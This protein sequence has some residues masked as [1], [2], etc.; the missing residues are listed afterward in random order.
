MR[1]PKSALWFLACLVLLPASADATLVRRSVDLSCWNLPIGRDY[2]RQNSP[3]AQV[4]GAPSRRGAVLE[5]MP[6]L[7]ECCNLTLPKV[8]RFADAVQQLQCESTLLG[9]AFQLTKVPWQENGKELWSVVSSRVGSWFSFLRSCFYELL[10]WPFWPWNVDDPLL[11]WMWM[12][13]FTFF[14]CGGI[15]ACWN[16]FLSL[17]W[18]DWLI[19]F[20]L[21]TWYFLTRTI[22]ICDDPLI[23][24]GWLFCFGL[25]GWIL[26]GSTISILPKSNFDHYKGR[27]SKIKKKTNSIP[28]S[29]RVQWN[30]YLVL[31]CAR[32]GRVRHSVRFGRYRFR[33]RN[34]V[35][36][37]Y[38]KSKNMSFHR[39]VEKKPGI[40]TPWFYPGPWPSDES[41]PQNLASCS[42]QNCRP[43][44]VVNRLHQIVKHDLSGGMG[45]GAAATKR[46]RQQ[47]KNSLASA[48]ENFLESW[49]SKQISQEAEQ[50]DSQ[51]RNNKGKG[52]NPNR[53]SSPRQVRLKPDDP[54]SG[55]PNADG[56]LAR[57]L[58]QTLKLCLNQGV[59][60]TEVANQVLAQIRSPGPSPKN[61]RPPDHA[62]KVGK[63]KGNN[64]RPVDSSFDS[65]NITGLRPSEWTLVPQIISFQKFQNGLNEGS[66]HPHNIVEIRSGNDYQQFVTLRNAFEDSSPITVLFSGRDNPPIGST[67]TRKTVFRGKLGSKTEVV[68]LKA[69]GDSTKC[70]WNSRTT[71]VAKKD[72][73][74]V[75][76]DTVRVVAPF[77]YRQLFLP[78]NQHDSPVLVLAAAAWAAEVPVSTLTGGRWT[79][80]TYG[81]KAVL[82][83]HIRLSSKSAQK[84]CEVSGN[85]GI[86]YTI[87]KTD[88]HTSR[89]PVHWFQKNVGESPENFFRRCS[90]LA[91]DRK[92]PLLLRQGGGSDLGCL[93]IA[94]DKTESRTRVYDLWGVPRDWDEEE[95]CGLLS[96][97]KW[98]D[99]QV[100]SKKRIKGQWSWRIRGKSAGDDPN[101]GSWN[102]SIEDSVPWSLEILLAPPKSPNLSTEV[103][104]APRKRFGDITLQDFTH[105]CQQTRGRSSRGKGSV[106]IPERER[107]RS[108]RKDGENKPT[109]E[110]KQNEQ[111]AED[112]SD[113]QMDPPTQP[114]LDEPSNPDEAVRFFEWSLVDWGGTG[115]CGFR[116]IFDGWCKPENRSSL[117]SEQVRRKAAWL[118][119]ETVSHLRKHQSK[120]AEVITEP[121]DKFLEKPLPLHFG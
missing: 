38:G 99:I 104:P 3:G 97:L 103:I 2:T 44:P 84:L 35:V 109:E 87:L 49:T 22:P 19:C 50:G 41:Q 6:C 114:P 118:R 100:L 45:A 53:G 95:I 48:L 56:D 75:S 36:L 37:L 52:K 81:S 14:S 115:D 107:S 111:K 13:V 8:T 69:F 23:N 83:G 51:M 119:S 54:H 31:P 66:S 88:P 24:L 63:G 33:F 86:F 17:F 64:A 59:S 120:F 30:H 92:Q 116:A 78:E 62:T 102:Y 76:K 29:S 21:T 11:N 74:S 20:I 7:S 5:F 70:P 58:I 79:K 73:P 108:R 42:S 67:L 25:C 110:E 96:S 105:S 12:S 32:V 40:H 82:V 68:H 57:R 1:K 16:I 60:D 26:D 27:R 90:A 61:L 34:K 9:A 39:H 43:N 18:R 106:S 71:T 15:D 89:S 72:L 101:Q 85:Q 65:P 117:D 91:T 55:T 98:S 80:Q 47:D 10:C 113:T 4:S 77:N 94:T 93:Q 28:C 112:V 46:K 121:F